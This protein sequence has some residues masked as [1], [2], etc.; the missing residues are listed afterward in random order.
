MAKLATHRSPVR[1]EADVTRATTGAPR[2][3]RRGNDSGA[4][5]SRASHA[6]VRQAR[7]AGAP[8]HSSAG[9]V[10][11]QCWVNPGSPG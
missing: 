5:A 11:A 8:L 3:T 4:R 1:E 7:R 2:N 10:L 9:L 6:G